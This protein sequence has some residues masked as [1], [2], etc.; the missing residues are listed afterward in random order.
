MNIERL[1]PIWFVL[2]ASA[3]AIVGRVTGDGTIRG[4]VAGMLI[5]AL[6][7]FLLGL[8]YLLLML[9]RPNLPICRCRQ[10]NHKG[11]KYIDS[12]DGHQTGV[13][14]RYM[15]PQCER[16]YE[17]SRDRFN[18]VANDGRIVPYMYHTKW[19]RWKKTK[20]EQSP[21]ADVAERAAPEE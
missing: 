14:I 18:E 16:L 19:G 8:M 1:Y 21:A 4:L 9:W 3:G 7:V 12:A 6:P 17:L 11:Y 15:C 20:A 2:C 10:C 13:S 5:A